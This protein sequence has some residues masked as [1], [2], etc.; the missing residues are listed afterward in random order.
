MG[1]S[2]SSTDKSNKVL[3]ATQDLNGKI[4]DSSEFCSIKDGGVNCYTAVKDV[5][6]KVGL[7]LTK[8]LVRIYSSGPNAVLKDGTTLGSH[9]DIAP[10]IGNPVD[11]GL[12]ES[13]KLNLIKPGD[14]IDITYLSRGKWVVHS[15]IFIKWVDKSTQLAKVFDWNGQTIL[16]GERDAS[17]N[18]CTSEKAYPNSNYCKT[19]RYNLIKLDDKDYYVYHIRDFA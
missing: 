6:S 5:Y 14:K 16:K 11:S 10:Y 2:Q 4:A 7:D 13:Q 9:S 18:K 3:K 12:S 8:D 1:S 19:Y 17:G 15:V